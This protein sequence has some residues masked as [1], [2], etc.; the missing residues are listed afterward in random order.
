MNDCNGYDYPLKA[1]KFLSDNIDMLP[2]GNVLDIA[3]GAGRN[4]IFLAEH[5]YNVEGVDKSAEAVETALQI[6]REKGLFIS[7]V[8]ADLEQDFFIQ[9]GYYDL[10]ICFNYLQRSLFQSIKNGLRKGGMVVY[11]TFIVDQSRFGKPGNPDF[12]L[13]YNELLDAF[14]DFRCLRYHEGIFNQKK[15]VAGIIAER[16]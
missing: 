5:G 13:N 14:R 7:A 9:P 15:A 11:E 16:V 3:M 4:S 8:V 2:A 12:L 10:I 6:A 1:S